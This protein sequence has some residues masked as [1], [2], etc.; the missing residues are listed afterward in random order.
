M[1]PKPIEQAKN[2]LLARTLPAL[3]RARKRAEA[4]AAATNTAIIDFVDGKV[5]RTWP[6]RPVSGS[7]K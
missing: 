4:L 1:N 6:S 3:L 2:P 5:V 7:A